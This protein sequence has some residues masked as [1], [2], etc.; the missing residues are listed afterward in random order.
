[1]KAISIIS[2]IYGAIVLISAI[3][4]LPIIY[5]EKI[6][7]EKIPMM[8]HGYGVT[9]NMPDLLGDMLNK[10]MIVMPLQAIINVLL[11]ISGIKMLKKNNIGITYAKYASIFSIIWYIFYA[12]FM[13]SVFVNLFSMNP[14]F[15]NIGEGFYYFIVISGGIFA[16]AYP[17]FLLFYLNKKSF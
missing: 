7:F 2:I 17:V 8:S 1:M 12:I 3:I 13:K 9:F 5:L 4:S 15:R 11:L 14:I 16:C 6:L 10:M